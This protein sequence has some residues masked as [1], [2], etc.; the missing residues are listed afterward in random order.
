LE[1]AKLE[2]WVITQKAEPTSA[3]LYVVVIEEEEEV[4]PSFA[5]TLQGSQDF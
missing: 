3:P 5:E 4:P 1:S 2:G